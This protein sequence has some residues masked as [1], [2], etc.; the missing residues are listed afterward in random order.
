MKLWG[1]FE[2]RLGQSYDRP[3]RLAAGFGSRTW[4]QLGNGK[5]RRFLRRKIDRFRP[6][7][8]ARDEIHGREGQ[9][10][11]LLADPKQAAE[12]DTAAF[13]APS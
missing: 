4:L 11:R 7:I 3:V 5:D 12:I 6:R 13:A 10:D 1:R 8:L 9:G 2:L